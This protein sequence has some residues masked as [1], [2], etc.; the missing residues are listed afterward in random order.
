MTWCFSCEELALVDSGPSYTHFFGEFVLQMSN[1]Q[2]Q[3]ISTD[4][5]LVMDHQKTMKVG[6]N[7]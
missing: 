1:D 6:L 3:F 2:M 4:C 5:I 7:H